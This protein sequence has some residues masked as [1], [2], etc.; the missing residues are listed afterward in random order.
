MV[1]LTQNFFPTL[2]YE[3]LLDSD[4]FNFSPTI[5]L[6]I[7]PEQENHLNIIGYCFFAVDIWE[8]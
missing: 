6:F 1:Q 8:V 3:I 4:E 2:S 7:L 5:L